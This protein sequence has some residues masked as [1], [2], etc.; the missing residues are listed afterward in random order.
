MFREHFPRPKVSAVPVAPIP[1]T[2]DRPNIIGAAFDYIL[3]F[4]ILIWNKENKN[5]F[6]YDREWVSENYIHAALIHSNTKKKFRR[7]I[8]SAK[9]ELSNSLER[10]V[11]SDNLIELSIKL[12]EIDAVVRVG[13]DCIG[14]AVSVKKSEISELRQMLYLLNKSDWVV[15]SF[16]VLNPVF[17]N[18]CIVGGAD[19]DVI[20][21][22][23]L[24]E[25]KTTKKFSL[26]QD[27]FNQI[28]GYYILNEMGG[29]L[30]VDFP[31]EIKTVSV[32]FA[33]FGKFINI[34]SDYIKCYCGKFEKFQEWFKIR[35]KVYK[36]AG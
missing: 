5:S 1:S 12:A 27:F 7:I 36:S 30:C 15:D 29:L 18:S 22:N 14:N 31:I 6:I 25:I 26:T 24:I 28:V 10:R 9:N 3:R 13:Y 17:N 34:P 23:R 11:I 33:R 32:Y 19:C 2:S 4:Q 8:D 20:L 21:G 35:A 16:C